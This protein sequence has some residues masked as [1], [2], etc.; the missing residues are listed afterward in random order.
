ML[1]LEQPQEDEN[2]ARNIGQNRVR[3][4]P[5]ETPP[6]LCIDPPDEL[7]FAILHLEYLLAFR[8][9]LQDVVVGG[10]EVY[11]PAVAMPAVASIA[12]VKAITK[13]SR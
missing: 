12:V 10:V 13:L 1:P 4:N 8:Q 9:G 2:Q 6:L 5:L 11:R 3:S 7:A